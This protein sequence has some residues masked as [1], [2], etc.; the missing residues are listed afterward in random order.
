MISPMGESDRVTG[1]E[2][3]PG[4]LSHAGRCR[5]GPTSLSP[6][7]DHCILSR[8]TRESY[9]GSSWEKADRTLAGHQRDPGP[10][11][12]RTP[13]ENPPCPWIP[14]PTGP[15]PHTPTLLLA[16]CVHSRWQH[17]QALTASQGELQSQCESAGQGAATNNSCSRP[18]G[19]QK[20]AVSACP[21]ALGHCSVERRHRNS[22]I[23][24]QEGARDTG[25]VGPH[26]V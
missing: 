3:A 16:L 17:K 19:K 1:G 11:A 20:G 24:P 26:Q 12:L 25:Q 22:R 5:R 8:M 18:L 7:P 21:P 4:L 6:S 13:P 15:H 9:A 2:G 14:T 23:L 10:T